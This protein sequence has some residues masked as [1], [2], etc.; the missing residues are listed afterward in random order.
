MESG[1]FEDLVERVVHRQELVAPDAHHH[2]V[3]VALVDDLHAS[4]SMFVL[5]VRAQR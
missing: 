4:S 3:A 1:P 5:M 2:A